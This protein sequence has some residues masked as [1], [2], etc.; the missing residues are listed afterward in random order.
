VTKE[1]VKAMINRRRAAIRE[2]R[3]PTGGLAAEIG[4]AV[5][6]SDRE[7]AFG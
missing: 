4:V 1:G 7:A 3:L 6:Q 2:G 5:K